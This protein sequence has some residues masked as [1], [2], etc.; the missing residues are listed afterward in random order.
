[1]TD[2]FP[3]AEVQA[4]VSLQ[5]PLGFRLEEGPGTPEWSRKLDPFL[6]TPAFSQPF[7]DKKMI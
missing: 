3:E 6:P 2:S 1:M 5:S 7:L 4:K